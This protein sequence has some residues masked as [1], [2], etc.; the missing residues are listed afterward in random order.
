[1]A[2]QLKRGLTASID[3]NYVLKQGQIGIEM[4][5]A[6]NTS[7][8]PFKFKIGDGQ[9]VWSAL[10]Y[11]DPAAALYAGQQ[12]QML[13]NQ[14]QSAA[15]EAKTAATS[16]LPKSGGAMTSTLS[17]A[18]SAQVRNISAGETDLTAGTSDLATGQIHIV[19]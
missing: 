5:T 16:K 11:S 14:A 4:P 3:N 9:T 6:Q 18:N 8:Y 13:A 19:Y 1:M 7:D 15:N 17:D 10:P 2:I 12:A